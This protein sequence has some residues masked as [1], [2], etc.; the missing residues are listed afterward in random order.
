[1]VYS[2]RLGRFNNRITYLHFALKGLGIVALIGA[3][4]RDYSHAHIYV[5]GIVALAASH[6]I[7]K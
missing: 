3:L 6:R 7:L 2:N 4:F 1:M 5:G